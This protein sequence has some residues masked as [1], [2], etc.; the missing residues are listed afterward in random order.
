M[1]LTSNIFFKT[2][3]YPQGHNHI[4]NPVLV[5]IILDHDMEHDIIQYNFFF[6]NTTRNYQNDRDNQ[7]FIV[8][9]SYMYRSANL[10]EH[11]L[12]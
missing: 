12:A 9:I 5:L 10:I 1:G 3:N 8:K 7:T 2:P 4:D 6:I 11:N